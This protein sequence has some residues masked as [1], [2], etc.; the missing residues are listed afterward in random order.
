[1]SK[2]KPERSWRVPA[3]MKPDSKEQRRRGL[4]GTLRRMNDAAPPPTV[5]KIK[6][7]TLEEIEAKYG[8][9]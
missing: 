1:M 4:I 3:G 6:A 5:P 9:A 8:K 7:P 2:P